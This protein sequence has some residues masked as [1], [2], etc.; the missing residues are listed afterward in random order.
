MFRSPV[1]KILLGIGMIFVSLMTVFVV[2][3]QK[4]APEMPEVITSPTIAPTSGLKNIVAATSTSLGPWSAT[5]PFGGVSHPLPA[6]AIG[7]K[8]YV[9]TNN[10]TRDLYF[11][12]PQGDGNIPT[13]TLAWDDHGG[14]PQGYTAVNVD[15]APFNFR[16]GHILRYN[17][18][19]N[20]F[21]VDQTELASAL[22]A[23]FGGKQWFWDTAVYVGFAQ[24]KYVFH[25]SGFDMASYNYNSRIFKS[26]VPITG[27]FTDTGKEHPT[28]GSSCPQKAGKSVF[29]LPDSNSTSGYIYATGNGCDKIWRIRVNQDGSL[30]NWIDS[31]TFPSGDSNQHGDMFIIGKTIFLVRGG[32]VFSTDLDIQTGAPAAWTDDPPDLPEQQTAMTTWG[33]GENE[34]AS[35]GVIGDYVY[36]AGDTRVFYSRVTYSGG[37]PPT[38]TPTNTGAPPATPTPT[39]TG[40]PPTATITPSPTSTSSP[41]PTVTSSLTPTRTP[42]STPTTTPTSTPTVT[43]T[44]TPTQT[45]TYTPTLTPTATSTAM[46]SA[47]PTSPPTPTPLPTAFP[48]SPPPPS[49]TFVANLPTSTLAP[50]QPTYTLAPG[51]PTHTLAPGVPTAAVYPEQ[52]TPTPP[53]SGIGIPW[54]LLAIPALIIIVG[55]A[56]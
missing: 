33:G 4:P 41:T 56:F 19:A 54:L 13:W 17:L 3:T 25:L 24:N 51:Q 44:N 42:T 37:N 7:N 15:G 27:N 43:P 22:N 16:N 2:L 47:T 6:F 49:P 8:F 31:G 55:F 11:G 1:I 12:I 32:K 23:S 21:V 52:L 39:N 46:P 35:W 50:G 14:G 5:T 18:D 10:N 20:G 26:N 34:G 45:P 40:A 36:V 53:V 9:H 38:A 29:F 28:A 48:T 30:E